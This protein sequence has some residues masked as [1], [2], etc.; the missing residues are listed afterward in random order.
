MGWLS[1]SNSSSSNW[2]ECH[3]CCT[4]T[5]NSFFIYL[6]PA[7][8]LNFTIKQSYKNDFIF[9]QNFTASQPLLRKFWVLARSLEVWT[10]S[11][12]LVC[13]ITIEYSWVRF[14][15]SGALLFYA[16]TH[17]LADLQSKVQA[18]P[19]ARTGTKYGDCEQPPCE[20][21]YLQ[22]Y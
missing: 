12:L 18:P 22:V 10:C 11:V 8:V 15:K 1:F 4:C 21:R 13:F 14:L 17:L 2:N 3:F 20:V 19:W 7:N 16:I 6:I 5:F 9:F